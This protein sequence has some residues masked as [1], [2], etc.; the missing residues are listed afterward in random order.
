M[1]RTKLS[2][3]TA[4]RAPTPTLALVFALLMCACSGDKKE[5]AP[6]PPSKEKALISSTIE[7]GYK[8]K[9]TGENE[10]ALA[11]FELAK[12][13]I[14]IE[15]GD[16]SAQY[17]SIL[18]DIASVELRT[19]K[20]EEALKKYRQA[21]S[22]NDDADPPDERLA[23]GLTNRVPMTE[24]MLKAGVRCEEPLVPPKD[25]PLPYFPDVEKMQEAMGKL[26]PVVATCSDDIPEAVTLRVFITGD[27]RAFY[28]YGRGPHAESD[29]A[30]CVIDRLLPALSEAELPRFR[31]CFRGFTYPYMVGKHK[32]K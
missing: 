4:L 9:R 16:K 18:D 27:G 19:G 17:A 5:A 21:K 30:K 15:Y 6:E 31:A 2:N 11:L 3:K 25:S 13:Q 24:A 14:V 26:N 1:N 23:F 32:K 12:K 22:L 8:F 7:E 10:A 20:T 28:A 29:L